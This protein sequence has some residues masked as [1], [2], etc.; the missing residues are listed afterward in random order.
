[1]GG[2]LKYH[3]HKAEIRNMNL[4]G[5]GLQGGIAVSVDDREFP[6]SHRNY[7]RIKTLAYQLTG[8]SLSDHKQNMIYG[9]LAR[10]LR[11]LELR[12]FDEY[13][14]L[15]ASENAVEIREFVNAITTNLTAFFR[16]NHH[17]D[18][19][20]STLLPALL[21]SNA[22]SRRLRI[23]SAGCSTGEEPYSIAMV[24]RSCV[25]LS[26]WDAKILA[27]DLDSNVVATGKSAEFGLERASSVPAAYRQYLVEDAAENRVRIRDDVQNLVTFKQLNL[28]HPWPMKGP[29]DVIFCRNVVIYFDAP[30]QV[31]LFNRY[32]EILQPDGHLFIGHSENLHKICDRFTGLGRT[33]YR[34]SR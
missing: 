1:V 23:W 16:E 12:N 19:L 7:Q 3:G 26:T 5:N 10:R 11:I 6:M 28:L 2:I 30:T 27:T 32:A 4:S 17:F 20:K 21:R 9:R 13:C 22:R 8:I 15:L 14:E 29:F 33:I 25:S 34:R 18:F 31:K 24:L